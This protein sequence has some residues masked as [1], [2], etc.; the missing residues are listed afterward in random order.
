MLA[1]RST[2]VVII[3]CRQGLVIAADSRV[4]ADGVFFDGDQKVQVIAGEPSLAFC[5][6]GY[7]EF[8]E[9]P[10]P[11]IPWPEVYSSL[12]V[13]FDGAAVVS[14][15]FQQHPP[16]QLSASDVRIA[17]L[18]LAS[19]LD[20]FLSE[21][22]LLAERFA[23]QGICRLCAFQIGEGGE[24]IIATVELQRDGHQVLLGEVQREHFRGEDASD[25][26]MVGE[27]DYVMN[28]VVAGPRRDLI[29]ESSTALLRAMPSVR[30]LSAE[31]AINIATQIVHAAGETTRIVPTDIGIGG[32]T[33]TFLLQ[34]NEALRVALP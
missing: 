9:A 5:I 24:A 34:R 22:P 29:S 8:R 28:E 14:Q 12:R 32:P 15:H 17:A 19:A 1:G 21:D 23:G 6:T 7:S 33:V 4:S 31:D 10:P 26:R 11:G 25:L 27:V 18:A 3:P 30:D 13:T 20:V 16:R 2:L